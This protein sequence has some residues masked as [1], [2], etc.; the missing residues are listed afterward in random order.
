MD[1][2]TFPA[3]NS[4]RSF[5]SLRRS[6]GSAFL[7]VL[8]FTFIMVMLVASVL[9]WSLT[10]RRLNTD[11][12]YWLEASNAAEALA[13]YGLSQVARLYDSN[14]APS[15]SYFDPAGTTAL[16]LPQWN[17]NTFFKPNASSGESHIDTNAISTADPNGLE[18]IALKPQYFGDTSGTTPVLIDSNGYDKGTNSAH[19]IENGKYVHR[20]DIQILAKATAVPPGGGKPVTAYVQESISVRGDPLFANAIFYSNND[21]EIFPGPQMDIYGPVRVNGNLFVSSQGSSLNFHGTVIA[22]GNVYHAWDDPQAAGDGSSSEA[23]NMTAAVNIDNAAGTATNMYSGGVW[24]DST[25]GADSALFSGGL[26]ADTSTALISSNPS[27]GAATGQLNSRLSSS[28]YSYAMSTWGGQLQTEAMGVQAYNPVG[29]SLPIG[30]DGSGNNLYPDPHSIIDPPATLSTSDTYYTGKKAVEDGKLSQKAGLYVQV[31]VAQGAAGAADTATYTLYGPA[32]SA[33]TGT[34]AANIGPNGGIKLG[35]IPSNLISLVPYQATATGTKTTPANQ[36]TYTTVAGSGSNSGKYAWKSTTVTGGTLTKN[37][38]R[39]YNGVS[40][41]DS[42]GSA[43]FSGGSSATHTD[44]VWYSTSA[45][46]LA[47]APGGGATTQTTTGAQTT[48]ITASTTTVSSSMY[49]QREDVGIDLIQLDMGKLR[50]AL[51]DTN[52]NTNSDS[53]AILDASGNVWGNGANG[54]NGAIYVD[55]KTNDTTGSPITSHASVAVVNGTVASGSSLIP[56]VNA[57]NNAPPG[58]TVATDAPMYVL[59]NFNA[60]GSNATTTGSSGSATTPDD[61]KTDDSSV[62]NNTSAEV[63]VALAADAITILSGDYFGTNGSTKTIPSSNGSSTNAIV[64]AST[65]KP[66]ATTS[67]IEIAAAFLTG[68]V[69]TGNS[70]LTGVEAS[71]GGAHNLPRFLESWSSKTVDIRGSLV[72]L[73]KSSI[74]KGAWSTSYYGAPNRLWGFDKIFKFGHYPP[75]TPDTITF[76]RVQSNL[77]SAATYSSARVNTTTGW[78]SGTFVA[79]H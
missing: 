64:S 5:S 61:G 23:L 13:E 26:Y 15:N 27:T 59:G 69:P 2:I 19:D 21:L 30:V 60:D 67:T 24:K 47:A 40:Y 20:R 55:V 7:T 71:S 43:S 44:T 37:T 6:R 3:M 65:N 18:L 10:E 9:G 72:S 74:A 78:S 77:V 52:S 29:Y 35:T 17:G 62:T 75:Q 48:N 46:A 12:G 36:V 63:P 54:W 39:T 41:S 16:T 8:I 45:G 57:S 68:L 58:L 28:F 11:N 4:S 25:M 76:R 32:G 34:P 53:A 33:P 66:T 38:T 31:T 50:A 51:T 79:V 56:T 42:D 70:N 73:Y 22:S 14:P 49:D 1:E